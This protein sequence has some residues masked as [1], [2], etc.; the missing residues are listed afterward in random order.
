MLFN[1]W[2][3]W[4]FLPVVVG[5]Y[6][7]LRRAHQN[8]WLL[9]ASYAFYA[10]W[11]W[12]FMGLLALSTA[13]DFMVGRRLDI[14]K[15]T[16]PVGARRRKLLLACSIAVNLG[17]LGFFKYFGFF[18]DSLVELLSVIAGH[19][20]SPTGLD[21]IL[22]V[23][24]SF[25]T[26]QSMSYT[27]DVYR[28][29]LRSTSSV[30]DFATF[31]AFFPQLVAGPIVRASDLLP[32]LASERRFDSERFNAGGYLILWGL[33]KKVVVADNLAPVVNQ[34]F[35][36]DPGSLG[37]ATVLVASY[38]FAFQIY[39]D[40]SGYTD[41]ARGCAK[42]MGFE[43]PLNFDL[44]YVATNPSEFWRRWHISLSGWLRDYLYIPLG[45]NRC[46][47]VRVYVNL[48][49]TML[50]GGLW[51]GASWTFIVW[52]GYQGLLLVV[53][54]LAGPRVAAA[55]AL[56][57]AG[58]TVAGRF[59]QWFV[60]F[61]L[62]CIGW[63]IFRAQ[64][65]DQLYAM[66]G[67]LTGGFDAGAAEQLA[68]TTLVFT[69]PVIAVQIAQHWTKQL[70][71]ILRLPA[72]ARGAIYAAWLIGITVLGRFEGNEFIYFQF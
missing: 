1:S 27:I 24:I 2:V 58:R 34:V 44:P 10:W 53:W 12:R 30:I 11:D 64:S 14:D 8:A 26:F 28:G 15:T 23:G 7:A 21:V 56:V 16:G 17:V 57:R 59:V 20:V 45:G 54:R 49:L 4:V 72:V 50:L 29:R 46:G 40:F 42:L 66:L 19:E 41:I 65:F 37:G 63:L 47:R 51:H 60:F 68:W 35:A 18:E 33:F 36:A 22:P 38:A 61:H 69:A 67:A 31:V 6:F 39:C 71:I 5:G 43:F 32:Q 25:Y 55:P 62:V 9:V 3:F 48:M 13:V 52:G 70:D